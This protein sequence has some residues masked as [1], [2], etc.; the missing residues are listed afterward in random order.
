MTQ[1]FMCENC[2]IKVTSGEESECPGCGH[3]SSVETTTASHSQRV[4][5][6]MSAKSASTISNPETDYSWLEN[7]VAE[8]RA[9]LAKGEQDEGQS[10][11]LLEIA[12]STRAILMQAPNRE[13][14][15]RMSSFLSDIYRVS[16]K[17]ND[18][19]H[20]GVKGVE[21]QAPYFKNQAHN[22]ILDSLYSMNMHVELERWLQRAH[23]DAFPGA[24]F[25]SMTYSEKIGKYAEALQF[26]EAYYTNDFQA[27]NYKKAS[28]LLKARRQD[29]S[30]Q[31]LLKLLAAGPK[32]DYFAPSIN[33]LAYAIL[34]PQGRLV[35]AEKFLITAICTSNERERLNAFSNLAM[36]AVLFKEFEAAKRYATVGSKSDDPAISSE[37]LLSLCQ[38]EYERLRMLDNESLEAWETLVTTIVHNMQSLNFDD[39]SKFLKLLINS[40]SRVKTPD[41]LTELI[42]TQYAMLMN[43][44]DW[45]QNVKVREEIEV[46]RIEVLSA[47]YLETRKYL[48]LDALFIGSIEHFTGENFTSLLGYLRTPFAS[49]DLRRLSLKI[50]NLAFLA[51]WAVFEESSEVLYG[52]A[53]VQQ[54]VVLLPLAENPFSPSPV[55]ELI[56][57]QHDLDLDFALSGRSELSENMILSLSQSLFDSVRKQ[58]AARSDCAS[59]VYSALA[60]DGSVLVRDAIRDNAS[61]SPEIKALA[62]LGSL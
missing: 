44:D 40:S 60:T 39:A 18:A 37:S 43:H 3:V 26:C 49:L 59:S 4:P 51:E 34:I 21:S 25:Y 56:L 14:E 47:Y 45:D 38:I 8:C 61:C 50:Q 53:K 55:L 10:Q 17:F 57:S 16:G 11:A 5:P 7:H 41:Q 12:S 35:E 2:G 46:L 32:S 27:M 48:E 23:D 30:E 19:Y 6:P 13:S 58:I 28:I 22:S 36:V 9:I 33:T 29:E 1:S 54:E 52:L 24:H 20:F 31:V 42:K 62:A 15:F